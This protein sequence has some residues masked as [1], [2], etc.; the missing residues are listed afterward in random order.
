VGVQ[1][2]GIGEIGPDALPHAVFSIARF[3]RSESS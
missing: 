2:D 1:R 3:D